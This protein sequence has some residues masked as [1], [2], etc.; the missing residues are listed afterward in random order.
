MNK[1]TAVGLGIAAV[2]ALAYVIYKSKKTT[3]AATSYTVTLNNNCSIPLTVFFTAPNG[4]NVNVTIQSGQ[5]QQIQVQPGSTV[6]YVMN[7]EW[8]SIAI[9]GNKTINLCGSTTTQPYTVEIYNACIY[10]IYVYYVG[11]NGNQRRAYAYP[12]SWLILEV[13][14]N[15][16]ITIYSDSGQQIYQTTASESVTALVICTQNVK[17]PT[18]PPCRRIGTKV[19]CM[20]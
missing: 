14:P 17:N 8:R 11:P 20:T 18:P 19:I 5:S 6:A 7:G 9:N 10:G 16:Q 3:A 4:S 1:G 12:A 15:S 2:G 13:Q